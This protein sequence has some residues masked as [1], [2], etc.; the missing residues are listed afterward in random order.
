MYEGAKLFSPSSETTIRRGRHGTPR[1]NPDPC[2]PH[3]SLPASIVEAKDRGWRMN[4]WSNEFLED[5]I[6]DWPAIRT[7]ENDEC[8]KVDFDTDYA[9]ENTAG[10]P[11]IAEP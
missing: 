7:A 2:R 9:I 4:L 1:H 10:P 8:P 6:K 5:D 11:E 3:D